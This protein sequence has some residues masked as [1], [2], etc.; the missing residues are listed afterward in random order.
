GVGEQVRAPL[1]AQQRHDL[2]APGDVAAARA[3]Q[4]LAEGAG[5]DVDPVR[6]PE[7]LRGPGTGGPH[8]P[9][10]VGAVDHHQPPVLLGQTADPLQGGE[11]AVQGQYTGRDVDV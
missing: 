5:V 4:R 6:D 2:G 10:G 8:E 11:V 7:V 3:A 9:H 1:L